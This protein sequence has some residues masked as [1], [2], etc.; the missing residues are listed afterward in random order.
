MNYHGT[1]Y[2]NLPNQVR[3]IARMT[4]EHGIKPEL[5]CFDVGDLWA[6]QQYIEE[7]L[8]DAPPLIQLCMGIKFGIPATTRGLIAMCD[9]LP[10]DCVW[11]AFGVGPTEMPM[12]AQSVLMGGNVRVGLEDNLY[13]SAGVLA[14]NATLVERAVEIIERLGAQVATTAEA[15]AELNLGA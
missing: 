4:Q 11:G 14:S 3:K 15:R 8:F 10:D 12:V 13:L 1:P 7:G 2:L 9:M 5:E 6:T